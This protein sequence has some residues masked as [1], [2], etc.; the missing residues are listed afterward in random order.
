MLA[1]GVKD[2]STETYERVEQ[3]ARC[4]NSSVGGRLNSTLIVQS[5][6]PLRVQAVRATGQQL[7]MEADPPEPERAADLHYAIQFLP[8]SLPG[9]LFLTSFYIQDYAILGHDPFK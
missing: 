9:S 7:L 1:I 5:L 4:K 6:N 2:K 3:I 8:P